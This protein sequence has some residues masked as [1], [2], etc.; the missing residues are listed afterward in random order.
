[1]A[2]VHSYA[3]HNRAMGGRLAAFLAEHRDN[4]ES[5]DDISDALRDEHDL[6]VNARTLAR[7]FRELEDEAS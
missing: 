5:W 1:M 7:W 3:V 2:P 4:G 6:K